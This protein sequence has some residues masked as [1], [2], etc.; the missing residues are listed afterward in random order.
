ME[1][2]APGE[3]TPSPSLGFQDLLGKS[4]KQPGLSPELALPGTAGGLETSSDPAW[5]I[6]R[7]Y[8][9]TFVY[10]SFQA[11]FFK[12][13]WGAVCVAPSHPSALRAPPTPAPLKQE[14]VVQR[15]RNITFFHSYYSIN[16]AKN[17]LIKLCSF[18][19]CS[20]LHY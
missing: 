9:I 5:T 15:K 6:L 8:S 17:M 14:D 10:C 2:W 4:P 3:A 11:K 12:T 16:K 18:F 7:S 1:G 13:T 20:L 19:L